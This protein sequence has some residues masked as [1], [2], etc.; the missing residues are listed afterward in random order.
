MK[1]ATVRALDELAQAEPSE[2]EAEAYGQATPPFGPDYL[3][4]RAFD[5]RLI[6]VMSTAVA[7]AAM[8]SGVAQ[9]P[10]ADM[11][12]YG[13]RLS[14]F[15]YHSGLTMGPVFAAAREAGKRVV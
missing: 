9:R 15:V 7:Q 1:L 8:D 12:A 3:I 6:T 14:R 11:D 10:I 13:E 4:P 2:V 5:P